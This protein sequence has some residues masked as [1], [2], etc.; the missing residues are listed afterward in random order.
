M[1][2]T[3]T[4]VQTQEPAVALTFDD[5]PHPEYTPRLLDILARYNAHATFFMVGEAAQ[6]HSE[7]VRQAAQA[8]HAIGNHSWDHPSFPLISRRERFAQ[9][10]QCEKA[11]A[12]YGQHLFRPPYGHQSAASRL[13]A[14]LLGYQ[15]VT[16]SVHVE[17]WA[18]HNT[19]WMLER[20]M[21]QA[22]PGSI[23]LLHNSLCHTV[24]GQYENREPTLQAVQMFLQQRQGQ[25]RFVTVPE[26]LRCGRPW[27][28]AWY[29]AGDPA[30]LNQL[31][32]QG[33]ETRHYLERAA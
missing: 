23:I 7:I 21:H 20:L 33:A 14:F 22:Q 26:L 5:G 16:W 24:E 3:I 32:R 8:E 30:W 1:L 2:G 6:R 13:D 25:F 12:G 27:R 4:R 18:D 31:R 9:L 10:W 28:Q 19:G 29:R 15:V 17:D 11:L